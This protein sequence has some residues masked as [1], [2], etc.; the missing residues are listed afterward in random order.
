LGDS[1]GCCDVSKSPPLT[2]EAGRKFIEKAE[3]VKRPAK[4]SELERRMIAAFSK[5]SDKK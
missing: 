1:H 4:L 2:G 3:A 5:K